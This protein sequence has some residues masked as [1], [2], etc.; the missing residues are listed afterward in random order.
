MFEEAQPAISSDTACTVLIHFRP[1]RE[2]ESAKQKAI[3]HR[4]VAPSNECYAIS[5][6]L[7]LLGVCDSE[8]GQRGFVV[9]F[10]LRNVPNQ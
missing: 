6:K 8:V 4:E 10:G 9:E 1:H 2:I 7:H 3:P 5:R